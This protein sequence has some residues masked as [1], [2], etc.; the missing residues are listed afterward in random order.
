M[1]LAY[2]AV[3]PVPVLMVPSIVGQFDNVT[4]NALSS[5]GSGSRLWSSASWSVYSLSGDTD[6]SPMVA[7]LQEYGTKVDQQLLMLSRSLFTNVGV[8]T[9]SLTL[10]NFF[11]YSA[12][13]STSFTVSNDRNVPLVS[14]AGES[15]VSLKSSA[16]FTA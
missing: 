12:T 14:I 8:F 13:T 2:N 16:I 1:Q 11:G 4:I 10:Q 5:T 9:T 15:T 6:T 3:R 7:A